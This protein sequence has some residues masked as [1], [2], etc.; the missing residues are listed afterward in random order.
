MLK[1]I[2]FP[3]CC[4]LFLTTVFGQE[5]IEISPPYN[6]KTVTFVQNGQ[7]A[8]PIFRLGDSFQ[9]Q[10]DDLYG[11]EANYYYSIIH[12]DYDWKPSQLSK[13]EYLNGFDDQRIQD[14]TNSVNTLQI[15][16][17]YRI[18]FPNRLTQIRVSGNYMM[19]I[20]NEEK[21]VVFAKKFILYEELVAVPMQIKR[22]R[23]SNVLDQKQ[24]ID[25]AIKSASIN[26]Q[27]PLQNVKVMLMQNG[28][29]YNAIK[30]IKPQYTIGNDLIY[31]YDTETQFWGGNEFLFYENKDIRAA[32]N[33]INFIDSNGGIYNSHL[34]ANEARANKPYTYY[35]DINGNFIIKNIGAEKNEIEA[36]YSWVFF[37]LSAPNYFGKKNIYIN[38][39]FNNYAMNEENKM[40][41]NNE[42]GVY[43]KAIMVKQ[44]FTN[45][46]Y[47][48]ADDKGNIDEKNAIDGN[49][50]IT[51]NDYF[52]LVYYRENNQ[53]Y[54]RVIGKGIAASVNI[55]N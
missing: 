30:N 25:F 27:S 46:Q 24:N 10:F 35:P 51:E 36:D 6:I 14:Y 48:L 12:C 42:K 45:Y 34:Y 26:F 55:T 8:I 23:N 3:I 37:T 47:I 29:F 22:A 16:S 19:K 4:L 43:E 17:H 41:Y 13:N 28:K 21:E 49:F 44:G 54:D 39:M 50:H 2:L 5:Q 20:L 31:K 40:E 7:N 33:N 38:G 32:N 9:L 53:R 1:N 52:A 11:N 15:Y 18:S